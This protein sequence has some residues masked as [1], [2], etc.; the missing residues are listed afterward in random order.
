MASNGDGRGK[1]KQGVKLAVY[2]HL[3]DL[4]AGFDQVTRALAALR[5]DGPFDRRELGRY[6]ALSKEAR[7]ATN[8]YLTSVLQAHRN[9]R[10]WPPFRDATEAGTAGRVTHQDFSQLP[11]SESWLT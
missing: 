7:A 4:N 2:R 3:L 9:G 5:K 1:A 6:S 11:P 8:S 10:G